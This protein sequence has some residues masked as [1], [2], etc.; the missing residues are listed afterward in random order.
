MN[1]GLPFIP[2]RPEPMKSTYAVEK[3]SSSAVWLPNRTAHFIF[4]N[5]MM[6]SR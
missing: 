5:D 3:F 2:G 6:K 1:S 4:K